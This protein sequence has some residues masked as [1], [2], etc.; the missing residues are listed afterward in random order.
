MFLYLNH[1][2]KIYFLNRENNI[3]KNLDLFIYLFIFIANRYQSSDTVYGFFMLF[4]LLN[5]LIFMKL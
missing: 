5:I 2:Q 4:S 1:K 3:K